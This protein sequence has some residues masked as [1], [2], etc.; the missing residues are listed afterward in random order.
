M[1]YATLSAQPNSVLYYCVSLKHHGPSSCDEPHEDGTQLPND[2]TPAQRSAIQAIVSE[3]VHSAVQ[4][5]RSPDSANGVPYSSS[6]RPSGIASPL[7]INR[8]LDRNLED[9][10]LRGEYIDLAMLL[11]DTVYQSQTPDNQLR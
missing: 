7:G 2:F 9:K 10:I 8:P 11:P 3:S 6:P 5:L 1:A 4:S